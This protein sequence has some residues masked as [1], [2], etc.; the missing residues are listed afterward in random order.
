M[1]RV[2][3]LGSGS[4]G[5]AILVDGSAG[6]VLIDAGFRPRALAERLLAV[7]R[8]PEEISSLYL[9]HEHTDHSCGA[10]LACRRWGWTLRA[11]AATLSAMR[12]LPGGCDVTTA[13][14]DDEATTRHGASV[15]GWQVQR[16]AVPHDA[17]D[18]SAFVVTDAATGARAGIALDLGH[19]PVGLAAAF[20]RLDVLVVESNHDE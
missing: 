19:V 4:R 12:E 17:R 10:V 13:P 9:T 20:S 15:D 1:L 6:S 3:V 5:N 18:C 11:G 8:R 7:G 14:V 2:T 16:V